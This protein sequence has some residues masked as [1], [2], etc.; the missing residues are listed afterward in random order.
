[1]TNAS[2]VN[3]AESRR[4]LRGRGG[5]AK[6]AP[7][8]APIAVQTREVQDALTNEIASINREARKVFGESVEV[9]F[10][11]LAWDNSSELVIVVK[12]GAKASRQLH[13]PLVG[14]ALIFSKN[15]ELEI[16]DAGSIEGLADFLPVLRDDI[17]DILAS[18]KFK[19]TLAGCQV[20][21]TVN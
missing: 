11:T 16:A 7:F 15:G 1:M 13:Y 18:A 8:A 20:R 2:F 21:D 14:G 9:R 17:A 6:V 10:T 19:Q 12:T 4:Q 3:P 5:G